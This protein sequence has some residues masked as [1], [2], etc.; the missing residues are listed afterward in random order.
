MG[1]SVVVPAYNVEKY[2]GSALGSLV[3]QVKD[4][5]E[6]IVVNDGSTDGTESVAKEFVEK[7]ANVFLYTT[8]NNGLGPARNYGFNKAIQEYVYFF[9]SDDLVRKDFIAEVTCAIK[10]NDNPDLILFSGESFF[11]EGFKSEFCP[12][13]NRS[14]SDAFPSGIE[15][16][17]RLQSIGKN[18]SSACLYVVKKS[19]FNENDLKFKA[20]LHEDEEILLPMFFLAGRTVVMDEVFFHRRIRPG[21]IM[22]SGKDRKNYEGY[23]EVLKT[24][25]EFQR[26]HPDLTRKNKK[27]W[28]K[29]GQV[30]LLSAYNIKGFARLSFQDYMYIVYFLFFFSGSNLFLK[31]TF[32]SLPINIQK[33]LK[34]FNV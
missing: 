14:I 26:C 15:A 28:K 31:L 32:Y 23:L 19:F 21:S 11:D 34:R 12:N 1:V 24:L 5:D 30:I 18:F 29:R 6:I 20:I 4:A 2:L 27:L 22:T 33:Y 3:S 9:D 8:D 7:Y 10:K 25:V 16:Y 17:R 13:Y